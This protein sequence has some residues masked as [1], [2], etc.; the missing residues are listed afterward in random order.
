MRTERLLHTAIRLLKVTMTITT[1]IL[2]SFRIWITS[3]ILQ[4]RHILQQQM[5]RPPTVPQVLQLH[6]PSIILI[7]RILIRSMLKNPLKQHLL[8]TILRLRPTN[9][10]IVLMKNTVTRRAL[11][12]AAAF[13]IQAMPGMNFHGLQYGSTSVQ[14]TMT[15]LIR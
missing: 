13:M 7:L 1:G 12:T 15:I 10:L 9:T 14:V 5:F 8:F 4:D 3:M 6:L 11:D 2:R